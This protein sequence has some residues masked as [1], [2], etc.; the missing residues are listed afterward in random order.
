VVAAWRDSDAGPL[1]HSFARLATAA[2]HA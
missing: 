1:I 2:Y